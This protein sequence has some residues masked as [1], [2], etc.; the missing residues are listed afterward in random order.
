VHLPPKAGV[1]HMFFNTKTPPF[2]D[3]KLRQAVNFAVDRRVI[4]GIFEGLGRTTCQ[5]LPQA[6]PGHTPY[7]PYTLNPGG[8]WT[9]PDLKRAKALVAGSGAL[10]SSVAVWA[11]ED[12][13]PVFPLVPVGRYFAKL[14][15]DIGFRA[16]LK[17]V[18]SDEYGS[19]LYDPSRK[20]QMAFEAWSSDYPSELGFVRL[21][22]TCGAVSNPSQFCDRKLDQEMKEAT[23]LQFTDPHA[24]HLRWASIDR[25]LVD[26]APWVPLISRTQPGLLSER[27]GNYQYSPFWGPLVDQMWVR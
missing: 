8:A 13:Y 15:N 17:V 2:D 5:I 20:V 23:S 14:L 27:V 11:A 1:L 22:L 9:K 10:G 26:L 25:K 12:Y 6:F 24:A 21:V 3:P 7:C 4:E 19:A 18:S 16:T